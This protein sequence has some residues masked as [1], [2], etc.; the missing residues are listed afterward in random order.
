MFAAS[1]GQTTEKILQGCAGR[2]RVRVFIS[3]T[4]RPAFVAS[5]WKLVSEPGIRRE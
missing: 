4:V 5:F 3:R 1:A 2:L